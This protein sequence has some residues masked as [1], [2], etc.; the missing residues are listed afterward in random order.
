MLSPSGHLISWS[1]K[2]SQ[3]KFCSR[4]I[5]ELLNLAKCCPR[6]SFT[7]VDI[8]IV[9]I[10]K[11][12][13][14]FHRNF[15]IG[16]HWYLLFVISDMFKGYL[17]FVVSIFCIGVVTA[18]IGDIAS[19]FGATLGIKDSVTAIVFVALGTSIP[20]EFFNSFSRT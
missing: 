19:H 12:S 17:C 20:G 10:Y 5:Y 4:G 9:Y 13:L 18:I 16:H 2:R 7:D 3:R 11:C 15:I 1:L 6:E 14:L 8:W